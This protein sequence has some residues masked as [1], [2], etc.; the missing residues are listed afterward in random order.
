MRYDPRDLAEIRVYRRGRHLCRAV[1]HELSGEKVTLKD[2]ERARKER[3]VRLRRG[4]SERSSLAD[5]VL[6]G[7]R[8]EA[9]GAASEAPPEP[10][11][12]KPNRL[13]L[14]KNE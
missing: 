5:A 14:Y 1:C 13:K 11:R 12:K 3:R 10:D 4:I 7:K 6:E 9:S 2:V 8:R